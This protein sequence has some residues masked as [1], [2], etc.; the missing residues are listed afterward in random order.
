MT[1]FRLGLVVGKFSPL[2]LGHEL[3][4]AHALAC[5]EQVLVLGYSEPVLAGCDR[6][7]RERWLQRRFPQVLNIQLDDEDVQRRCQARGLPFQPMPGNA[8]ADAQQQAYLAWLLT[9]PLDLRPDAMFA[10]EAYLQPCAAVLSQALG[11]A[12]AP[13]SVDPA[14]SARPI[15]ATRIRADVHAHREWLHPQVYRDFVQRVVLLGGESTGKT[16]LAQAL[17]ERH[18][19]RWVPEYGR[20]RWLACGGELAL[21]DLLDIGRIQVE[22]EDEA[23]GHA[24]RLLFCDTSPLTTLGY[25][26]WMFGA[27]PSALQA[28]A[29]RRYA[30]TVLCEPDI[31]FEQ[32]GTR[33][34]AGFRLQ[35]Q[36]W[37]EARLAE[38]SGPWLRASGSV[39]Q[40]LQ[41]VD[42]ALASLA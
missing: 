28:L 40:R 26:G 20:E 34:P 7:R 42:A 23:A 13:V 5:C 18:E 27:Q 1:R 19:T 22:R 29:G 35:Q 4:I 12:V 37:Y 36:A 3:V 38:Q 6:A 15:S 21:Q 2:H 33:Q 25:A 17:A 31:A 32:D 14:R 8:A 9:A 30:L 10:S 24:N 16:M 41:Q 11:H 39:A